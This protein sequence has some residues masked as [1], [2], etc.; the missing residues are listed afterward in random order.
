MFFSIIQEINLKFKEQPL[1]NRHHERWLKSI[2][3]LPS[4]SLH[5]PNLCLLRVWVRCHHNHLMIKVLSAQ[6]SHFKEVSI[7]LKNICQIFRGKNVKCLTVWQ[8]MPIGDKA[9]KK[10]WSEGKMIEWRTRR[11]VAGHDIYQSG[12][13]RC[14]YCKNW[15]WEAIHTKEVSSL[16]FKARLRNDQHLPR[17]LQLTIWWR[18]IFQS[19]S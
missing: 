13:K 16:E 17:N 3:N 14:V 18:M 10:A 2:S 15:S 1:K 4:Q 19:I 5:H 7:E 6:N 8:V 11:A 9:S 12:K